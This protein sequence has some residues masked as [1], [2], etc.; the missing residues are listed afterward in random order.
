MNYTNQVG[1]AW[2]K[3]TLKRVYR[4]KEIRSGM[5]NWGN[6]TNY[7]SG[8]LLPETWDLEC[9]CGHNFTIEASTFPGRRRL[10]CCPDCSQKIDAATDLNSVT[11]VVRER[12]AKK[13]VVQVYMPLSVEE[14]VQRYA[15]SNGM[16][17]S[18]AAVVL[19][20]ASIKGLERGKLEQLQPAP[21]EKKLKP[22]QT[23]ETEDED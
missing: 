5:D 7:E 6:Y 10:N 1:S 20:A 9:L 16:S 19:L 4:P 11:R 8:L 17:F 3:L 21:A 18:K 13:R 2:G 22:W 15:D 23:K 14:D 12:A